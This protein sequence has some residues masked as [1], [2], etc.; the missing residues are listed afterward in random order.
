MKIRMAIHYRAGSFSKRWI[1]YCQERRIPYTLVNCLDTNIVDKLTAADG[2]L[3]HWNQDDPRETLVAP[4]VLKVAEAMGIAVFPSQAT[5]WYF[6][7]KVAQ[8][9]LLESV[10]APLVPTHVFYNADEAFKW[11]DNAAFPKVFKL[12][13]GA[14]SANVRL[15]KTRTE[16][17]AAAAQAFSRGFRPVPQYWQDGQRRYRA[18]RRRGDV[19]K[20]LKRVPA[21]LLKI[22]QMNR[23][24]GRERGYVYFQDFMPNNSFDTRVTVIGNRAFAYIRKVRPGDFRASGSG[25]I[26]YD[27]RNIRSECVQIA[28]EVTRRV[29]S[30]SMAFDFV[31]TPDDRP[32]VVEVSYCYVSEFV[33]NCPGHWDSDLKWHIGQ[34]WPEDVILVDLLQTIS[35]RHSATSL[36]LAV[37]PHSANL[38][39]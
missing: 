13:K 33:H 8:K 1:A 6:D 3:W 17:R 38:L 29:G 19:F 2:L 15:V 26:D 35:R 39:E 9:Y 7:D 11:I 28:F 37:E 10:G 31:L 14:G 24:M 30:Q 20:A 5:C 18:A 4:H 25:N 32:M 12:R 34:T 23:A 16:A 27:P 21:T 22:A 36:P